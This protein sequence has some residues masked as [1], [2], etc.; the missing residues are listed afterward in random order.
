MGTVV[1]KSKDQVGEMKSGSRQKVANP[2]MKLF[3]ERAA[4]RI[5][6]WYGSRVIVESGALLNELRKDSSR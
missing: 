3:A 5:K 4:K 1:S 2:E 6:A